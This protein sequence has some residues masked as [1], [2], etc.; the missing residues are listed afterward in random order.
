MWLWTLQ[1][2]V[3]IKRVNLQGQFVAERLSQNFVKPLVSVD[4]FELGK[5]VL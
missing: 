4:A 1:H 5:I 3:C 2:K